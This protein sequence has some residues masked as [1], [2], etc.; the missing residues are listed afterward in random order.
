MEF[1]EILHPETIVTHLNVKDKHQALDEMAQLF[2]DAGVIDDK[3]AY[4]NDVYVR[5][6]I[7]V[8]GMGNHIAIPHGRSESVKTPGAAVAILENEVEWE[9]LDDTG[10][11]VVILFAVG[12]DDQAA[13]DH[14]RLLAA[15][16]KRLGDDRIVNALMSANTREDVLNIFLN[17]PEETETEETG[18]ADFDF[19]DLILC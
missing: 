1:T 17:G 14:L 15:F 9:S 16:S 19:D 5:E 6:G 4:L 18:E 11:K 8:T 13:L 10:A 12:N 3:K 7:G 2:L